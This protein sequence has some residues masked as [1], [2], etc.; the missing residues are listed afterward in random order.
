MDQAEG[1]SPQDVDSRIAALAT[2]FHATPT[3]DVP[4]R[5]VG[6][7]QEPE[8]QEDEEPEVPADEP[9][10]PQAEPEGQTLED[11][12]ELDY[13]GQKLKVPKEIQEGNLRQADY[14]KKTQAVAERSRLVEAR[15]KALLQ[16]AQTYEK[17]AP[18]IMQLNQV[19]AQIQQLRQYLTPE[20][21][22][23]N[24]Q[25]FSAWGTQLSILVSDRGNLVQGIEARKAQFLQQAEQAKQIALRER[26]N[27]AAPKVQS[28]IKGFTPEKARQIAEYATKNGFSSEEMEYVSFSAPAV[29][30]LWKAQEYD[31]IQAAKSVKPQLGN[32]PPVAKPGA[33]PL[34]QT[35]QSMRDK[36][37]MQTWKKGGGKDADALAT[38]LRQR[39]GKS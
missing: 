4:V 18:E 23:T 35:E 16:A 26:L 9:T 5:G 31:R 20:L 33:R 30:A 12:V 39:L 2:K 17:L 15:E 21:R 38:I 32:L 11:L 29:I 27:E 1:Q 22:V 10:E 13:K 7:P 19:D 24:P 36:E 14:T 3:S 6:E 37:T 25:E 34:Q 28:A 8:H